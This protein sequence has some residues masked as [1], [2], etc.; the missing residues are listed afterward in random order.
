MIEGKN[1]KKEEGKG[2][3]TRRGGEIERDVRSASQVS[4]VCGTCEPM[5]C[6]QRTGDATVTLARRTGA[7]VT[8]KNLTKYQNK[9][10]VCVIKEDHRGRR[11]SKLPREENT[12][13]LLTS[14]F[15]VWKNKQHSVNDSNVTNPVT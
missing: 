11:R 1:R 5:T 7:S 8:K 12:F 10:E 3:G 14:G 15:D 4:G 9:V 13:R 2:K 6:A